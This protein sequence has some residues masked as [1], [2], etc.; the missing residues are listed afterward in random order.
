LA[1]GAVP[2]V[3]VFPA[4]PLLLPP[5]TTFVHCEAIWRGCSDLRISLIQGRFRKESNVI[6]LVVDRSALS[7]LCSVH[8]A[9]IWKRGALRRSPR[10]W[11]CGPVA[12]PLSGSEHA[13]ADHCSALAICGTR[14]SRA[15]GMLDTVAEPSAI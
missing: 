3:F 2:C 11:P 14:R 8:K 9:L 7:V 1:V 4:D 13:T 5:R 12:C 15:N 10:C 6:F